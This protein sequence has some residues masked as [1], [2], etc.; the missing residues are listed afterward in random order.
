MAGKY[1]PAVAGLSPCAS[2]RT[3]VAAKNVQDTFFTCPSFPEASSRV[4]V[5]ALMA[6]WILRGRKAK[7]GRKITAPLMTASPVRVANRNPAGDRKGTGKVACHVH[8]PNPEYHSLT[9]IAH[10]KHWSLHDPG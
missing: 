5:S 3:A 6:Y 10:G 2:T 9:I 1:F 7:R 4:S 8:N